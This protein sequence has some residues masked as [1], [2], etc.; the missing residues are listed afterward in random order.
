MTN[1]PNGENFNVKQFLGNLSFDIISEIAFGYHSHSQTSD[2]NPF[3]DAFK[4]QIEGVLNVKAKFIQNW[5]P[6]MKYL[7][8]GPAKIMK[9]SNAAVEKVLTEVSQLGQQIPIQS[10]ILQSGRLLSNSAENN[11]TLIIQ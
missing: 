8:F 7:P 5:L 6:F 3:A 9:D 11:L 10:W 1:K 4:G 2:I